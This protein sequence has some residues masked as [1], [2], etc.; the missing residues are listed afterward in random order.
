MGLG[1]VAGRKHDTAADDHGTAAKARIVALLDGREE[2]VEVGVQDRRLV[3]HE[4]MFVSC[5]TITDGQV[6]GDSLEEARAWTRCLVELPAGEGVVL[7]IVRDEPWLAFNYY[8]GDLRSRIA[9]NVDL[10]TSALELLRLTIHETYPGH[11]AERSSKEHMLVRDR[12]LLE[13]TL[14]LV[15]TPQS[16]V[17]EGIAERA[18]NMLLEGDG[19]AALAGG[20]ARRRL[21]AR[22]HSRPRGRAGPRAV[23]LGGRQR[24]V[25]AARRRKRARP[26]LIER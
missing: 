12:G 16:L 1:L 24:G 25:D 21:R 13:E 17:S 19:G 2:R 7:E 4:H 26:R 9:V 6:W 18:P 23:H 22:S 20:H 10:P 15:P 5:Q 11:H 14:V 3:Q 8:L